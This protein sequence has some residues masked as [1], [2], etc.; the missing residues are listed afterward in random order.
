MKAK[1][2]EAACIGCGVCM[3]QCPERAIRMRS[4]E[5]P[6]A[7]VLPRLCSA[8]GVCVEV[9]PVEAIELPGMMIDRKPRPRAMGW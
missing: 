5:E 7:V 6:V 2:D 8:C 4:P 3:V 9:C 1:V